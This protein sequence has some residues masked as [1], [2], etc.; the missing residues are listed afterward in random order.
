MDMDNRYQENGPKGPLW[1]EISAGMRRLGYNR[2]SKRCKEKWENINKYF[3]KVKE[4]NKR[5]PEDSK[6][7]PY[8]HQLEA[9]YRKKHT[10]SVAAGNAA[11]AVVPVSAAVME[12]HS[13]NRHEIEGKKINDIDKRNNGGIGATPQVPTSNGQTTAPTSTFDID[14][15]A[16][17]VPNYAILHCK[18]VISPS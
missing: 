2:N 16:K 7:C 13:L 3:K 5:R 12:Q 4:S 11:N 18:Y 10:G 14:L 1:E 6:T 17:K 9:I 8:F 15:G